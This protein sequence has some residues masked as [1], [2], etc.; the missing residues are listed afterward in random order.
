MI[1]STALLD[2]PKCYEHVGHQRLVQAVRERQFPLIIL[3]VALEIHRSPRRIISGKVCSEAESLNKSV[4]AGCTFATYLMKTL[5]HVLLV[6]LAG[7]AP[8]I[9]VRNV[10]DDITLQIVGLEKPAAEAT[11]KAVALAQR[12]LA[13]L[14]LP[15]PAKKSFYIMYGEFS[16]KPLENRFA[17]YMKDLGLKGRPREDACG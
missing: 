11:I 7:V 14:R 15:V 13:D 6:S 16:A 4:V 12:G 3:T 2:I 8:E 1:A 5:L 9:K 10:V 17:K